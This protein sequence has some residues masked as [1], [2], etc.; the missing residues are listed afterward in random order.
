TLQHPAPPVDGCA[1]FR[2]TG[3]R[4]DRPGS[5]ARRGLAAAGAGACRA[6]R[7]PPSAPGDPAGRGSP[8]GPLPPSRAGRTLE[9]LHLH[10]TDRAMNTPSQPDLKQIAFGDLEHEIASTRRMLAAI[11]SGELGWRPHEKSWTLGALALHVANLLGWGIAILHD[12]E[13]DFAT[14]PPNRS[15]P[16]STEA[17]LEEFEANA[18]RFREALAELPDEALF[19]DWTLRRGAH[20]ILTLPSIA[21]CQ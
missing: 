12:P 20:V 6:R 2:A 7:A 11:P 18:A 15:E 10:P 5:A 8:P 1:G 19:Q 13:F 14:S 17:I 16:E 4:A 9:D 21:V 3:G